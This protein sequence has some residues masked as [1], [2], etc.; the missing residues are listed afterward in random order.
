MSNTSDPGLSGLRGRFPA[1]QRELG[2]RACIFADAP[3]GTQVPESVISAMSSYMRRGGANVGGAFATSTETDEVITQARR[4]GADFLGCDEGEIIFGPNSTTIAFHLSRSIARLVGRG[5]EIVVTKLDHDA[6]V[7]PWLILAQER[8]ATVRWVDVNLADCTLDL[9]SL[10]AALSARTRL[11]AFTLAS[12][13]MGTVTAA[14]EVVSRARAAGALVIADGV[15]AAQHRLLDAHRAGLDILFTSPYKYFGPHLG[16][17]YV[18]RELLDSLLPYKVRPSHDV[19]PGRWETGTQNHE[20]LAGL[21]A[22]IDYIA[23]IGARPGDAG[24]SR[25]TE[26][27]TAMKLIVS[28][29][30]AMSTRFL[31][32]LPLLPATRLFGIGEP[33]R[34]GERTPTFAV[35][36][37]GESPRATARRLAE[38]GIFV[39]DGN[40]YALAIMEALGLED[41]GGAVRI[42]FCHYNTVGEVDRTLEALAPAGVTEGFAARG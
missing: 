40:Y 37:E 3:G 22:A 11:V 17:A 36:V 16:M 20:A 38:A 32:R 18:R 15:H 13:A 8:G 6:N 19:G 9:D 27:E 29:E 41:S 21:T 24:D 26:L 14:G 23:A 25:R 31:E 2:G 5:D 39:W 34:A 28:H 10:E 7:A 1:L 42:G 30:A 33:Q 35:R 12:N 4:A